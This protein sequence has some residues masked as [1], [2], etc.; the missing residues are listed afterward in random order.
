MTLTDL[1]KVF[2]ESYA[3][4]QL[5]SVPLDEY[6]VSSANV[7][8]L[9]SFLA[10]VI[11]SICSLLLTF[12]RNNSTTRMKTY[13]ETTSFQGNPCSSRP[14]LV[15]SP[16]GRMQASLLLNKRETHLQTKHPKLNIFRRFSMCLYES[17]SKAFRRWMSMIRVL[18]FF[19]LVWSIRF[20]MLIIHDPIKL[21]GTYSQLL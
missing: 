13:G 12:K 21:P 20:R 14:F 15:N 11:P 17:Q 18:S 2:Q 5:L 16:S 4:P 3:F 7:S 8:D 10:Y 19:L 9:D 6:G 1:C